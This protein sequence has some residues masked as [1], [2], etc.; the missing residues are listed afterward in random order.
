MFC[1]RIWLNAHLATLRSD[2]PG[3]GEVPDGIVACRDTRIVYA[4][5]AGGCTRRISRRPSA[6][7]A[8]AAG[9]LRG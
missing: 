9:S 6:S 8:P 2:R 1:D 7:T 3:M 5:A 4:G